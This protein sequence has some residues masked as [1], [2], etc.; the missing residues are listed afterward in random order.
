MPISSDSPTM[1][2]CDGHNTEYMREMESS[3]AHQ[4]KGGINDPA[5]TGQTWIRALETHW[6]PALGV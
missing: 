3:S 6:P 1:T 5:M 2:L 4:Q